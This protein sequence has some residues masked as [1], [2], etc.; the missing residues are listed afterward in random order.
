M[1]RRMLG[2]VGLIA[3]RLGLDRLLR[4]RFRR[5]NFFG[6]GH[7]KLGAQ[8]AD[9]HKRQGDSPAVPPHQVH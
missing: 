1:H 9:C 5:G 8:G 7:G 6:L 3:R 4:L 2:G